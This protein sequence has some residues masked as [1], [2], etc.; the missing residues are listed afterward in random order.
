MSVAVPTVWNLGSFAV[1]ASLVMEIAAGLVVLLFYP[2]FAKRVGVP[3]EPVGSGLFGLA[4]AYLVMGK[5]GSSLQGGGNLVEGFLR[6]PP[7]PLWGGVAALIWG[8]W[9]VRRKGLPLVPLAASLLPLLLLGAGLAAFGRDR[10][11]PPTSLPWAAVIYGRHRQPLPLYA[12][13]GLWAIGLWL[14]VLWRR[15]VDGRAILWSGLQWGTLLFLALSL[16]L[17]AN[18]V[19]G[20]LSG[21][22]WLLSGLAAYSSWRLARG[23]VRERTHERP[24]S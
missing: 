1:T 23:Q 18:P 10:F 17:P 11:G 19:A 20:R 21:S 5:L 22:E 24:Q 8:S 3:P 9:F 13:L 4:A 14:E 6:L 7:D 2:S 16:G 12:G 15:G